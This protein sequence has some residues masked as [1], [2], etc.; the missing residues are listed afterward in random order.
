[1]Y[2]AV[3]SDYV[4]TLRSPVVVDVT[5]V[6]NLR[7]LRPLDREAIVNTVKKTNRLVTVEEGWPQ[8]GV[9]PSFVCCCVLSGVMCAAWS[10]IWASAL[11]GTVGIV[12]NR[13]MMVACC[14]VYTVVCAADAQGPCHCCGNGHA[15]TFHYSALTTSH[16]L[17]VTQIGAEIAATVME[18]SAFDYLDAPVER[19]TGADVPMPY[20]QNLER[21][22]LPQI[23]DIT[24]AVKRTLS[25]KGK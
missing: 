5:Q 21:A 3:C 16:S 6:I 12:L 22:A 1:V 11:V 17:P 25:N 8:N 23:D 14:V 24:R 9:G 2:R 10:L 15:H 19:I 20:T 13:A 4:S 18:T 7:S